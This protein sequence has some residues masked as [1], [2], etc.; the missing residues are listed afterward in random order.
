ME[1][2]IGTSLKISSKSQKGVALGRSGQS[3]N[4]GTSRHVTQHVNK[5]KLK[6]WYSLRQKKCEI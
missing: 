3:A 4:W 1:T 5:G 2:S 6:K